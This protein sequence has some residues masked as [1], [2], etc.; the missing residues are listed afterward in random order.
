MTRLIDAL[1]SKS[2]SEGYAALRELLRL[3]RDSAEVYGYIEQ[4]IEMTDSENSYIRTRALTLMAANARWDTD[5]RIDE[6]IDKILEHIT[7]AKPITARKFIEVLPE[8][9]AAKP[10]LRGDILAALYRADT[11]RYPLSMRGLVDSD[12]RKAAAEIKMNRN[13]NQ[14]AV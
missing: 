10:D 13:K 1:R 2:A 9:A 4:F 11:Q 7:D 12:I 5:C 3:S 6:N 8:L 14:S